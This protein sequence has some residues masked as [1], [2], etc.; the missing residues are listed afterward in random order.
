MQLLEESVTTIEDTN[1]IQQRQSMIIEETVS[2]NVKIADGIQQE[3]GEFANITNMVQNSTE[4]VLVISSQIDTINTMIHIP[5]KRALSNRLFFLLFYNPYKC[6]INKKILF[7]FRQDFLFIF[8][9]PQTD[10]SLL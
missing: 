4:Q 6:F 2:M 8:R 1:Q 9:M 7:F 10:F 3:N 5:E